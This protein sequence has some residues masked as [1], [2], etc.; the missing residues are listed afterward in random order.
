MRPTRVVCLVML[1]LLTNATWAFSQNR[2][3]THSR[4]TR[5]RGSARVVKDNTPTQT[6]QADGYGETDTDAHDVAVETL[7]NNIASYLFQHGLTDWRPSVEDIEELLKK[8]SKQH[9]ESTA[10]KEEGAD[11]LRHVTLE[12]EVNDRVIQKFQREARHQRAGSRMIGLGKGLGMLLALLIGVGG[13]FRIEEATKGYYTT[14]LRLTTVSFIAAAA[15]GLW[16]VR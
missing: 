14:W 2:V 11:E 3:D 1:W 6:W 5:S 15:T 12:V 7:T 8:N 9:V 13:Y 16:L 10:F 4:S